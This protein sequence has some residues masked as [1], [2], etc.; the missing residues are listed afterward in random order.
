MKP[1][2]RALKLYAA[3]L[4]IFL[5]I[6]NLFN[7][8]QVFAS[9]PNFSDVLQERYEWARPY[10]EKM[11]LLGVI[12]GRSPN[13]FAPDD[14]VKRVEF[15][16]MIVR[17]MGLEDYAKNKTLPSDFP[18]VNLI[19]LWAR[20]YIA[21][22]LEKGIISDDDY[23]NFRP[24]EAT[25]RYEAAVFAIRALGLEN[26]AQSIKNINLAF[27][28][29]YE[30]PL[31]ARKY[32]QLAVEKKILSGFEDGSFRPKENINRAQA[33]KVLN[34]IAEYIDIS[35]KM[36]TAR[37]ENIKTDF[38]N[39]IEVKLADGVLR[40]YL[41]GSDCK[42]YSKDQQGALKKIALKD[43]LP[44]TKL[45]IIAD[46][47][48]ANYIEA[49]MD[50]VQPTTFK[51]VS[52]ILKSVITGY[53][54]VE[55]EET[56]NNETYQVDASARVV[57]DGKNSSISQLTPGDMVTLMLYG[58][59]VFS[60]ES[61]SAQKKVS[62]S[63]KSISF[64]SKNPVITLEL[65]DGSVGDFEVREDAQV[66]RDGKSVELKSIKNQ[67]EV[68]LYVEYQKVTK[69][70][71]KSTKRS[72]SGVVKGISISDVLKITV[73]D[74]EGVDHT[75]TVTQDSRITKDK[76]TITIF[77]VKPGF[78]VELEAEGDEILK[79][80]VTA[81]QLLNV[82]RGTARYVHIDARVIVVEF[83]NEQGKVITLEIHFKDDTVFLKGNKEISVKKI[84]D[85]I[86]EGD[87]VIAAGRYERGIFYADVVIDLVTS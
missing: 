19:P 87:E 18:N 4:L 35:G 23:A 59:K 81:R 9:V 7:I 33:A 45:R 86:E 70:E 1:F 48:S 60:I 38:L 77:E 65:G 74:D 16:A 73:T 43:I 44:G 15:I 36:T 62:G 76:K 51:T 31:G 78:Y 53:V 2:N 17:L 40:T 52:G 55:N 42:V 34:Q 54:V 85:Y 80:E 11:A 46:G 22:A 41:V 24:E 84:A 72:V 56:K 20:S 25:K 47:N 27:K 49:F 30:I 69:I 75:F 67:D 26:E 14:P 79:M 63:V 61:E 10:V 29:T 8:N 28:D 3:F 66:K 5:T 6:M 57:K 21:V 58:E 71:A 13:V 83:K 12:T 68:V 82:V 64:L 32:V 50:D 39:Y 37:A